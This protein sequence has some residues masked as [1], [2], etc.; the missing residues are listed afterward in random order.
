MRI[1]LAALVLILLCATLGAQF[2]PTATQLPISV[3][4]TGFVPKPG[5]YQMTVVS[6]LTDA[7]ERSQNAAPVTTTT[8]MLPEE[9]TPYQ[10][11]QAQQ[12]SLY[13]Y[14][15]GL[16]RV[17]LSRGGNETNYDVLRYLRL[18]DLG[19]NPVLRDG[20]VITVFP[21]DNTVSILG[22]VYLPG[23]YEFVEGDRLSD[24][25]ALAQGF[26]LEADRTKLNLYRYRDNLTDFDLI[27]LDLAATPASQVALQ[28]NDRVIVTQNAEQRQAWK[29]T[30]EGRVKAPGEYLVGESTTL[31]DILKECGGPSAIGDLRNALY[32]NGIRNAKADPEFERLKEL[33]IT[34]MT[35]MEYNYLRS[36]IRQ[37]TGKYSVDIQKIW[38][39][40]GR[41]GNVAVRDGDYLY[42]PENL[43][44]VAVTGQ[45]RYPG[46]VPWVEG[47]DWKY[48]IEAAGGYTNNRRLGG[49]RVIR[50]A[51]GNWVKPTRKLPI[52]PGDMVFVAEQTDRD[53][54]TDVKDVVGLAAQIITIIIGI[55]ALTN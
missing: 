38:D 5:V 53:V 42:V 16:R 32:V 52:N 51:S 18:G 28:P 41:E 2:A 22:S 55:T 11:E 47:K 45:V 49:V 33:S 3:S 50:S 35:P 12:D 31:Y 15:Q 13:H 1:R 39:S 25:L 36:R 9:L 26:T 46:L 6:R 29:F 19:Q 23:E 10:Q 14:Y 34:Q 44:M 21:L 17:R 20:D 30:V 7:L 54:W 37:T 43:D 24:L 8:A 27:P 48:Y 40:E 4:V